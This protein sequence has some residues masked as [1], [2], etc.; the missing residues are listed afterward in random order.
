MPASIFVSNLPAFGMAVI[1]LVVFAV[2]L[3][4]A[5]DLRRLWL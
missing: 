3:E 4:L 1:L 5:S 2:T